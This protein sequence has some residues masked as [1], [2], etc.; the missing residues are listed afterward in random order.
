MSRTTRAGSKTKGLCSRFFPVVLGPNIIMVGKSQLH[1]DG[2]PVTLMIL[3]RNTGEG[4]LPALGQQLPFRLH[5]EYQARLSQKVGL[6]VLPV[7]PYLNGQPVFSGLHKGGNVHLVVDLILRIIRVLAK[8]RQISIYKSSIIG[9]GCNPQQGRPLDPG[10]IGKK[11]HVFIRQ[12]L[13]LSP[14][15]AC[16][17]HCHVLRSSLIVFGW[18]NIQPLEGAQPQKKAEWFNTVRISKSFYDMF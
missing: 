16:S 15:P 9:I 7:V 12:G 11:I 17:F 18:R 4:V 1:A 3:R 14:N 6:G 10:E 5:L 8:S 13:P 2:H